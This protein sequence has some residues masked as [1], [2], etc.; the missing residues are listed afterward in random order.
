MKVDSTN[1]GQQWKQGCPA[2]ADPEPY[3]KVH[4][5]RLDIQRISIVLFGSQRNLPGAQTVSKHPGRQAQA[6]GQ[7]Y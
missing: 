7:Q 6:A 3:H 1:Q 2:E 5:R 4:A